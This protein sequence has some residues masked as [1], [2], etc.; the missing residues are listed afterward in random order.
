MKSVASASQAVSEQK[1]RT[2]EKSADLQERGNAYAQEH[3]KPWL[4]SG[5]NAVNGMGATLSA[6]AGKAIDGVGAGLTSAGEFLGLVDEQESAGTLELHAMVEV[7]N[8]TYEAL[9]VNGSV[10][11]T[12]L[13]YTPADG[14]PGESWGFWPAGGYS[15]DILDS[16]VA[17]EVRSP[18]PHLGDGGAVRKAE[19][20]AEQYDA[21]SKY[22]DGKKGAQYSVFFYNCTDFGVEGFGAA[23]QSAPASGSLGI[24]YPNALYDGIKKRNAL[25][26]LD[27]A[28]N[29]LPSGEEASTEAPATTDGPEQSEE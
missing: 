22:I 11:H 25:D 3:A 7:P 13:E 15:A 10:G 17:G 16:Y 8:L 1:E 2:R 19:I 12:W 20:S 9:A 29:P 21:M 18:D 28:G 6:Y 26:G 4:V 24:D 5:V 23:G 27:V 14:S